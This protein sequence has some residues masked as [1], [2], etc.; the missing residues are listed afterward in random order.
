MP[1]CF[2]APS[3]PV[4]L[5]HMSG[6]RLNQ[7]LLF[8]DDVIAPISR[9]SAARKIRGAQRPICPFYDVSCNIHLLLRFLL[10]ETR[11]LFLV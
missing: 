4:V 7:V 1:A 11:D 5:A 6:L 3:H 9:F 2:S 8:L 10:G